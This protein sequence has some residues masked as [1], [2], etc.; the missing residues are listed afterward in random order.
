[1]YIRFLWNVCSMYVCVTLVQK[2]SF[3]QVKHW[4]LY[5]QSHVSTHPLEVTTGSLTSI[6]MHD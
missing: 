1:M 2:N 6:S 5:N 4:S 3:C